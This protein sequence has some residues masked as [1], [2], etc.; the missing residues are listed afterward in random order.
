MGIDF[1]F[2]VLGALLWQLNR[3]W[4]IN[5]FG[6]TICFYFV[7]LPLLLIIWNVK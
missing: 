5:L 6:L 2:G 1:L 3:T 4:N 7:S